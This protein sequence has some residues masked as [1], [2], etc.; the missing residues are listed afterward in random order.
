MEINQALDSWNPN[1]IPGVSDKRT[2]VR[3]FLDS[4]DIRDR[5][6]LQ[7]SRGGVLLQTLD[8]FNLTDYEPSGMPSSEAAI[9]AMRRN[10]NSSL[11]FVPSSRHMDG[12]VQ[13]TFLPS[14]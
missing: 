8:P 6:V 2:M 12:T 11:N 10:L 9:S 1:D 3:V 4:N 5:G 14:R 13:F 7:V